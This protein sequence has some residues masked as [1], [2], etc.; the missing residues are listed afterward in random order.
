MIPALSL[1]RTWKCRMPSY[2]AWLKASNKKRFEEFA[3]Q[4]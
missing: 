1:L 3:P 2:A 4:G